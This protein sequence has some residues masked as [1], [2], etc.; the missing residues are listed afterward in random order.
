MTWKRAL[1]WLSLTLF[2]LVLVILFRA[3]LSSVESQ[4]TALKYQL[5]GRLQAD[6][7]IVIVYID[8][9]AIRDMGR[10]VRRNFYAL[11]VKA[12]TDLQVKVIGIEV[13]FEEPGAEYPEYDE[14]LATTIA[15]AQRVVLPSYFAF[16]SDI[17]ESGGRRRNDLRFDFPGVIGV[18]WEGRDFHQ[19]L[20]IFLSGSA[21]IGHLNLENDTDIPL[22]VRG[23]NGVVPAFGMELLRVFKGAGRPEI[24]FGNGTVT[25]GSSTQFVVGDD[26]I[27]HLNFPGPINSFRAYPFLEVL[28]SYDAIRVDRVTSVPVQLLKDKIVLI[29]VVAEDH[30][31]YLTTPVASRYPSIGLHA[32]FL[33]NAL[34]S[35]FLRYPGGTFLYLLSFLL[36]LSCVG[37]ILFLKSPI[38]K[39]VACGILVVFCLASA[40]LFR[41]AAYVLPVTPPLFTGLIGTVAA[42]FYQQRLAGAAVH[43]LQAEKD[44]IA[45]E[46]RNKESRVKEIEGELLQLEA[47]KSADRTA[48]LLE[49]IRRY[50]AEIHALSSRA[51][52]MEEFPVIADETGD[53]RGEYEG[54]IYGR[55]GPMGPVIAFV[56]KIAD[57]NAPVLILG[58]SGTGKELVARAIH[59]R[60]SR[61]GGPFIAVNCGALSENLLESELFGHERGAFTGAVKDRLGRF[62]LADGGTIFLDEIGEVTEAFQLKLLRVLQEGE[63]ERVGG[64]R[65]IKVDV[66]VLAATNKDLKEQVKLKRFREDLFYRLNVLAVSLPPLRERRDDIPLLTRHFLGR[67]GGDIRVSRNVM[68]ALQAYPWQGNIRELESILTRC[69]LMARADDRTLISLKD[70]TEEVVAATQG[71]IALEDQVLESLRE[72]GFSRSSVSD[73]AEELGG[74]S[75]GTVAEYLRGHCLKAFVENGFRI[76][77]ATKHVSLSSDTEVNDRLRKKVLEY[78]SNIAEASDPSQSWDDVMA[79]LKPKTKNLPQR[80][81]PYVEKVAEAYYKGS[82]KLDGAP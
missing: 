72:K 75:R 3:P 28:R 22:F 68:N 67:E 34:Q 55:S 81:H 69:V 37:A 51:D 56:G 80:F 59:A 13:M 53:T 52:D 54:I 39:V 71:K 38:D 24:V 70:L 12:L 64:T 7:N 48:E 45:E 61:A 8:N 14:L 17:E 27:A 36:G 77:L 63:L 20:Q 66:R 4:V 16:V 31:V 57:N 30:S 32:T 18:D 35:R 82:F 49:E 19:P 78:L 33:D 5:R 2:P 21:G 41:S 44:A 29:S 46:L 42:L 25:I 9:D 62:E 65:T 74:L 11:M 58:E 15:K 10:P 73:T 43:A 79:A 23:E 50:K 47:A 76:E 1:A 60:S 40:M 6:S 26:A